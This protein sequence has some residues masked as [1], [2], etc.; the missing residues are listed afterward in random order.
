MTETSYQTVEIAYRVIDGRYVFLSPDRKVAIAAATRDDAAGAVSDLIHDFA[1]R[2][3]ICRVAAYAPLGPWLNMLRDAGA[4]CRVGVRDGPTPDLSRWQMPGGPTLAVPAPMYAS[5]EDYLARV[6]RA[7]RMARCAQAAKK[8]NRKR[9]LSEAPATR[10]TAQDV[11]N[12]IDAA[13]GRC[14]HCGSLAVESRPS[15]PTGA[16]VAWA[17]IGRRV[18]SLEHVRWRFGGGGNDLSNLAWSCLWCNTWPSERRSGSIDHGFY[19]PDSPVVLTV[20][21]KPGGT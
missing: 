15:S 21:K 14:A 6:D 1:R 12:V 11:W 7:A 17:Q 19:P 3:I 13:R 8:A 9:L 18:G 16:P 4:I 2:G 10:L 5:W 20:P